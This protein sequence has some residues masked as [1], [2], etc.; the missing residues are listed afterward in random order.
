MIKID[1]NIDQIDFI[2]QG[3]I[4]LNFVKLKTIFIY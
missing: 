4:L 3:G 2:L 1:N